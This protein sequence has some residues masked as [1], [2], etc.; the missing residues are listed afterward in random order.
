MALKVLLEVAVML[1]VELRVT[2]L[3]WVG[4]AVELAV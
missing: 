2:V 3:V 1:G 4:V